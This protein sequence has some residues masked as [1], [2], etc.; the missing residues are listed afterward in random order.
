MAAY[1][2]LIKGFADPDC[3]A[4][5]MKLFQKM[6][7]KVLP[8]LYSDVIAKAVFSADVHPDRLNFLMR[9]IAKDP[10]INVRSSAVNCTPF[11]K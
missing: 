10:T 5:L 4:E 3:V 9:G 11:G 6:T 2:F 1:V 7:G 8:P